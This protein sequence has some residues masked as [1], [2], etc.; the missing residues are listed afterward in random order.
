MPPLSGWTLNVTG[1]VGKSAVLDDVMSFL[2]NDFFIPLLICLILLI[3]WLGQQ[4]LLKR[5]RHQRHVM[6]A[7]VAIG[8]SALLV[9]I[10]NAWVNPWPRPFLVDNSVIRESARHAA[11]TIFYFPHDPTFPSNGATIAF[12]AGTGIWFGNRTAGA[13]IYV[14]ATLWAVARFYAGVHFFIDVASGAALGIFTSLFIS[15]IFMPRI[16]PLP[17]WVMKL[18]RSLYL[19]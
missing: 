7:A 13:I 2:V 16:E 8:I 12:A 11:E 5:D 18:C 14:L 17:T 9:L 15:K 1:F 3:L 10:I 6:N 4:D 19:A